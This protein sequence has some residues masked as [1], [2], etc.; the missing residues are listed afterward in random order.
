MP[1]LSARPIMSCGTAR[2]HMMARAAGLARRAVAARPRPVCRAHAG[3]EPFPWDD[4][5][6]A[7]VQ[8]MPPPFGPILIS[9]EQQDTVFKAVLVFQR[10]NNLALSEDAPALEVFISGD[11]A[12][13]IYALL[14]GQTTERPMALDVLW[15][16]WQTGREDWKLLRASIVDLRND[17]F[18]ARL[19]FGD[20]ATGE[21]KWDCDCRPS[22]ATFLAMKSGAPI[23][24]HK[25]VWNEA[26][27]RL[28]DTHAFEYIR[29]LHS[30][31]SGKP[32]EAA[33]PQA[34][35]HAAQQ[36][37]AQHQGA[38]PAPAQPAPAQR[39]GG[40]GPPPA[41][42]GPPGPPPVDLPDSGALLPITLLIRDMEEAVAQE[43]Y[44]LAAQLRDHHW[45]RLHS[46]IEMHKG[47]G[48]YERA[49]ELYV[50]LKLR[51][52]S[53]IAQAAVGGNLDSFE[54]GVITRA[55]AEK[56]REAALRAMK[57]FRTID[58]PPAKLPRRDGA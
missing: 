33:A 52:E 34:A 3:H 49:R 51:I 18:V 5:D 14:N 26:A 55:R 4:A 58:H 24:V 6:Y 21:V 15:Q 57:E 29:Q 45:M 39:R 25:R 7:Q 54:A 11:T 46:D 30:A 38:Q 19:F 50:Q 44:S 1:Q 16:M 40:G 35:P 36:A 32:S 10:V 41:R 17:V 9:R 8:F 22:D 56:Q 2:P 37:G 20:P 48:A 12:L 28:R 53:D 43:D 42:D 47:I 23:F 31:Q 27:T 13:G